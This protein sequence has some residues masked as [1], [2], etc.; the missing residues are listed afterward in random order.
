[1]RPSRSAHS[2]SSSAPL[3][4][5]FDPHRNSLSLLRLVFAAMVLFDHSFP[6]GGFHGGVDPM[7][8][9]TEGQ[10]S[11]GG[12]A[13]FGFFVVSGFLVTRSFDGSP[14]FVSYI[15]KRFLRIFPGF[16]VCL[17]VTVLVFAPLAFW[18]EH[19]SLL[20]YLHTHTDSP[21]GYLKNNAALSMNQYNIDDLL[22]NNPYAHL[23]VGFQAWDGSLWTL[24][25]EFKCYLGVMVL[26]MIGV[27]RKWRPTVLVLSLGLWALQLKQYL[28]PGFLQGTFLLGDPNMVRLAFI[29][30]LGMIFYLYR[31]KIIISNTLAAV[32][33]VVFI[34]GMRLDLYYGVGAVMWAYL[35]MWAAVRLPFHNVDKYG[36]FSYGLYIY[37]FPI[38]Q[39]LSLYHVNSWGQVPYVLLSLAVAM[40]LAIGSW[41]GIERPA[42]R[43]KRLNFRRSRGADPPSDPVIGQV[44]ASHQSD[45]PRT[46]DELESSVSGGDRLQN[47]APLGA[48][49]GNAGPPAPGTFGN[50]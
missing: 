8:G 10:E 46:V 6:L 7:W 22:G 36:D 14:N 11:F 49:L 31:D 48:S 43:L 17:L 38:E 39:M 37:A 15:W 1:M 33:L 45:A 21:S 50:G 18:Y 13:V 29:F 23:H 32:A 2:K 5:A 25:Y 30:S 27:F 28:H 12:L 9:W 42:Q 41:Y 47:A 26:G 34:A 24:I 35:C 3:E 19:G 4:D 44:D 16:W 20:G 40:V